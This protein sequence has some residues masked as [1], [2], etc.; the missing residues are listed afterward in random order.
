MYNG[1]GPPIIS[2]RERPAALPRRFSYRHS[3]ERKGN[4][5]VET[6][7]EDRVIIGVLKQLEA[8]K[9]QPNEFGQDQNI[10]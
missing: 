7:A 3:P 1:S 8:V 4:K 10:V 5:D 9:Q 2:G 6:E